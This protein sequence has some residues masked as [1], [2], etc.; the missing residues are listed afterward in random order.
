[1]AANP[2]TTAGGKDRAR[3]VPPKNQG[4]SSEVTDHI[5]GGERGAPVY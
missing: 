3:I 4:D 2:E 5:V 1:M